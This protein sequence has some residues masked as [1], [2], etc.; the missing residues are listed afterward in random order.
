M[1]SGSASR[2]GQIASLGHIGRFIHSKSKVG[3]II[4]LTI[5][6]GPGQLSSDPTT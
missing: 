4:G 5:G 1:E 3:M 6:A 2:I